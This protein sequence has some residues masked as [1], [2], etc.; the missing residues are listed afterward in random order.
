MKNIK[1]E[2]Q[3]TQLGYKLEYRN[4]FFAFQQ[5]PLSSV[6]DIN[7][8]NIFLKIPSHHITSHYSTL[9]LNSIL[10]KRSKQ[11]ILIIIQPLKHNQSQ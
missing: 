8:K 1:E 10:Y 11:K 4:L 7:S 9:K 3:K 6:S 2:Q 5:Q